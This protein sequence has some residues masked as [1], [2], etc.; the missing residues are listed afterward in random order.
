[1]LK[2]FSRKK[3]KN[4]YLP[5]QEIKINKTSSFNNYSVGGDPVNV[6]KNRVVF[7]A[8]MFVFV[9]AV[10]VWRLFNVCVMP[11][12]NSNQQQMASED[13]DSKPTFLKSPIKRADILDRNGAII[14]TSL[15]TVNLYAHPKKILDAKT[16]AI[17]LARVLPDFR[18]EDLLE[19]LSRKSNFVYIKRNLSPSQQYQI[20]ALGIPGLEFE[21]G[22]KRIY[23]HKNL[24]AH[25]VGRTNIDNQG[26]A[27]IEK[28][29][30]ERLTQS[31]IPLNLTIDAGVQD[32][33]RDILVE[34]V[35]Q[36]KADGAVA[37]LMDVNNAEIVSMVSFPDFDPNSGKNPSE[38]A[39]FN[40]A[41]LG[42]YEPGSVFKIFN[43]AMS[44]E[45]GKIRVADKFDATKPLK[46]RSN[47]IKDYRGE[48][49]WL[50]VG[51]ILT[52]SSNIGSALMALKVGSKE[53]KDFVTNL[54]FTKT[55]DLEVTE[56]AR[57]IV[58]REWKEDTIATVAYGYGISVTPIHVITA[59][60]S[61][62]NGGTYHAPSLLKDSTKKDNG[63]RVISNN[64]SKSMRKLLRDV[65]TD[66][67]GKRANVLGY[68]VAGKT[69]TANKLV[70]GRYVDKKVMATFVSTFPASNPKYALLVMM[71]E[72][73]GSKETYGFTTSGWNAV[74]T[75][76][77]I[78]EA[79]APQLNVKA[80]YDLDE[81]RKARII[82]AS[83]QPLKGD[84]P[85]R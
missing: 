19:R 85:D 80:N 48:N 30:D 4:F 68:E 35:K 25:I 6:C 5:G 45:S 3:E 1:M 11:N 58:P 72:P 63:Y 44:L 31:N 49:R 52:H 59:F 15:P 46:V 75:A 74:P 16:A 40:F 14:A 34:A 77:K 82:E 64:T 53:Q 22:E 62:I 38:R 70:N 27:G 17:E 43:T 29:L 78:I 73:K 69:G 66:G 10:I 26:I 24:F 47:Y 50:S 12:I 67:S 71:D 28:E 41:T 42:V 8:I 65:V 54:G 36:F 55:I 60:S 84:V 20:N 76:A 83:G 56:K 51:E 18:Y 13:A 57:P 39:A 32:T 33:I 37:V 81:K 21:S 61:V 9:Y 79:I 7:A 23:P 2:I